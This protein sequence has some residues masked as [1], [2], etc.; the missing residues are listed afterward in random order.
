MKEDILN[1]LDNFEGY[2][3]H[4]QHEILNDAYNEIETLRESLRELVGRCESHSC[5]KWF[6]HVM[7]RA[8][9]ALKGEDS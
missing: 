8:K 1:R 9:S 4:Y 3:P 6:P 7:E 2:I 5:E